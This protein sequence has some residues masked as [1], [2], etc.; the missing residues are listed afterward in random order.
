LGKGEFV[1]K[2]APDYCEVSIIHNGKKIMDGKDGIEPVSSCAQRPDVIRS[3]ANKF[4]NLP[5]FP[6][7]LKNG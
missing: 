2:K 6:G 7:K 3:S 1:K 4:F 5:C